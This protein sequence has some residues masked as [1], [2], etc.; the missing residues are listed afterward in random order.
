MLASLAAIGAISGIAGGLAALLVLAE[1]YIAD[2]GECTI[3]VNDEKKLT[4]QGGTSLL[5]A[6]SSKKIF[7]PSACGGRGTCAYCKLKILDGGG[8]MG[9]TESPLLEPDEKSNDTRISCQVKVR[10]DLRIEIPEE[11]FAVKEFRGRVARIRDLTHDI[12]ELRIEL[13]EPKTIDFVAGQYVQLVCPPYPGSSE[14]VS[15]AYSMSNPPSDN[16]AV[17]MIIRLVPDGICTTW[18]FNHLKEGE[19]VTLTGPY[20]KFRLTDNDADMVWVAGGSGMAPFWSIARDMAEHGNQRTVSYFFGALTQK[21]L[22]LVDELHEIE[23]KLPK[24]RFIP[25]LSQPEEGTEWSGETGL[26]TTVAEKHLPDDCPAE[27]Y[28]CGSGGMIRA[29]CKTLE[30]KGIP[31]ERTY[32]DEFT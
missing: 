6:L 27:A 20:G 15:R 12:K 31:P 32:Y 14:Q 29:A 5:E 30:S 19:E 9:P 2:Y 3:T 4:V 7:I 11:L 16:R 13:L 26:I 10:E 23:E 1:R 21:D 22:F 18:V 17:E 8:P 24:F 28:L 25:A